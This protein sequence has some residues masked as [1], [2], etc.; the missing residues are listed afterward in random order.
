LITHIYVAKLKPGT[1]PA[2]VEA[3]QAA[4]AT[5][6]IEGMAG[7]EMGHDAGIR[8]GNDDVAI[9]A[10]F[11]D[12]AAWRRYDT[13]ELH[14][15]IRAEYARPI[16][17]SQQRCQFER[18]ER[19]ARGRLRNVTLITLRPDAPPGQPAHIAGRL[20]SLHCEGMHHIDAGPDLGLQTSNATLGVICDF[21]DAEGYHVYDADELHNQIRRDDTY[22][23]LDG[24]RRVQFAY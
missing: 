3:W 2:A 22:P 9:T 4:I 19:P 16:V 13:D 12:E 14:N 5:L 20:A 23:Y 8:D 18:P 1:D 17:E 15:R 6:R 24:V 7:L 11:A 21:D 10:D